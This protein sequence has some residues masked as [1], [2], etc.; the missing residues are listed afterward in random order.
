MIPRAARLELEEALGD[1]IRFVEP[2]DLVITLGAGSIATL[3]AR[4]LEQLE[5]L[6][7][8]EAQS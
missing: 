4:I 3:G 7:Q 1:R 2:G 6:E 8:P 5:Q